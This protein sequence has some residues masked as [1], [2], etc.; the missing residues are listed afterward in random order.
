MLHKFIAELFQ[1]LHAL[2]V[3]VY[4]CVIPGPRMSIS[5]SNALKGGQRVGLC[6]YG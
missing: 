6:F 1:V 5:E 4:V 2:S 3:C